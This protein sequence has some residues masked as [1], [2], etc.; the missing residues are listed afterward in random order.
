VNRLCKLAGAGGT[1]ASLYDVFC[2]IKVSIMSGSLEKT[3]TLCCVKSN[4]ICKECGGKRVWCV[5]S[6]VKSLREGCVWV[7]VSN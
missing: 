6:V 3:P 1:S 2:G 5:K 7:S 4:L